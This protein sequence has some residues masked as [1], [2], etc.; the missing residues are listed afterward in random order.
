MTNLLPRLPR[1]LACH[2]TL[3]VSAG[4]GSAQ[5]VSEMRPSY[6][7]LICCAERTGSTLLGDAL[8]GTGIA[9]RPRAYF[10]RAAHFNPRYQRILG[11]A[12]DDDQYLDR[13][14]SVATTPN[15][16][17][18]AKVHWQHF[19]NLL[20]RL[21]R[22]L[23]ASEDQPPGSIPGRLRERFPNL[24][25]IWLTRQNTIARAISHYRAK[26]TG[27]WQTDSRWVTDDAGGEG[28]PPFDFDAINAFVRAGEV[29]DAHWRKFFEEHR[30]SSLALTYEDLI[31]DVESTVRR[32]LEFLGIS[33]EK[34]A[35]PPLTSRPQSDNNS[36]QWEVR[37]R[38]MCAEEGSSPA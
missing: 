34:L 7:Y 30:I 6:C 21:E 24:R 13:V 14:I 23:P 38:Q 27:R 5:K 25:Y 16:V 28:E 35:I 2:R 26:K 31:L 3:V 8:I 33:S 36:S 9:G 10:N 18:G 29:E 17:F 1:S 22:G 37:Y 32:V 12:R 11:D 20:A 19:L 4:E 15:G